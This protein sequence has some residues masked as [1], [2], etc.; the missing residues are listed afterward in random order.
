MGSPCQQSLMTM[1]FVS[2]FNLQERAVGNIALLHWF[3]LMGYGVGAQTSHAD[4]Q[5]LLLLWTSCSRDCLLPSPSERAQRGPLM[6]L[7]KM[8]FN[9]LLI[10][11]FFLLLFFSVPNTFISVLSRGLAFTPQGSYR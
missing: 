3:P 2:V 11:S 8:T 6:Q 4:K 7:E 1:S 9:F 10:F 5:G